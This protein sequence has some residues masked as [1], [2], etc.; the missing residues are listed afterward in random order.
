MLNATTKANFALFNFVPKAGDGD[1]D[2]EYPLM[3]GFLE[4][5]EFK[6][7]VGAF[8]KVAKESG[9]QYLSLSVGNEKDEKTF[10]GRLFKETKPGKED[11]YFG[12]I[13]ETVKVPAKK[14]SE[15][16]VYETVWQ[17]GIRAKQ[18]VSED[19]KKKYISG[20]VYPIT[21]K[22]QSGEVNKDDV[23]AF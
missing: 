7:H 16:D 6:V 21:K 11:S 1:M 2:K 23:P 17:L 10:Y 8:L 5:P 3:S 19:G 18:T 4:N 9:K 14:K 12:Y 20:S 15:E 13:E 22:G